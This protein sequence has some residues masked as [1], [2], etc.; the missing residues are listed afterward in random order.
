MIRATNG[1][2]QLGSVRRHTQ[3]N[4]SYLHLGD[5]CPPQSLKQDSLGLIVPM[6]R[7]RDVPPHP[8]LFPCTRFAHNP[9][10][11]ILS[12]QAPP[13]SGPLLHSRPRTTR[14]PFL[15]PCGTRTVKL[16]R[17][18]NQPQFVLMGYAWH[19]YPD[20]KRS[21][22]FP[23]SAAG[24]LAKSSISSPVIRLRPVALHPGTHQG[25]WLC[26]RP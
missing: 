15:R 26:D 13:P 20:R 21:A 23:C 4:E 19:F 17:I 18:K 2:R 5:V 24:F 22:P 1:E 8:S 12:L 9:G 10:Q 14:A 11:N 6:M 7:R 25:K 16:V 3:S